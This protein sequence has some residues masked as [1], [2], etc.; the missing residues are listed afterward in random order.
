MQ[1]HRSLHFSY[2][3]WLAIIVLYLVP[4]AM[5]KR[6]FVLEERTPHRFRLLRPAEKD[7]ESQLD[8]ARQLRDYHKTIRARR[9]YRALVRYW[10][11]KVEAPLAQQELGDLYY[12]LEKFPKAFDAYQ[13]L[14]DEYAGLFPHKAVLERQFSIAT[15][16]M[17]R[18]K[19]KFLIFPGFEAPE[20]ALPMMEKILDNGPRWNRAPEVQLTMGQIYEQTQQYELAVFAYDRFMARYP[21]SPMLA[22]A[23]LG[24][25]RSL[26]QLSIEA[27]NDANAA[28]T[29][30]VAAGIFLVDFPAHEETETVRGYIRT[31][32]EQ[33]ARIAYNQADYYDRIARNP[34]AALTSYR[35]LIQQ[36]PQSSWSERAQQRVEA[37]SQKA[38][39]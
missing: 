35:L 24:K 4:D 12:D 9:Q 22:D 21:L 3:L 38:E 23:T 2:G 29:A 32:Q 39:H 26:Y 36:F 11:Q 1:L 37:L 20:R 15:N 17:E 5:A 30:V 33:R 14:F 27:P 8:H 19:G 31:L 7:P 6:P 25:A 13:V 16:V 10:P 34:K 18:R 28:E